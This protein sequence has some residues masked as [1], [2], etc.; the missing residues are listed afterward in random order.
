MQWPDWT[1]NHAVRLF[2]HVV[3]GLTGV[4]AY[5]IPDIPGTVKLQINRE[6]MLDREAQFEAE[7][8]R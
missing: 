6:R 1:G 8:F 4:I 2:Q 3:I 7:M 5:A